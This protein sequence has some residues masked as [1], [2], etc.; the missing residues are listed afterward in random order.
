VRILIIN[1]DRSTERWAAISQQFEAWNYPGVSV[2]RF[3]AIDG[4]DDGQIAP[5]LSLVSQRRAKLVKARSLTPTQIGCYA[6]HYKAWQQC[7]E[8]REELIIVEDDASIDI[9]QLERFVAMS[10]DLPSWLNCVRLSSNHTKKAKARPVFE[11]E[12]FSVLRFSKAHMT[13]VGYYLTPEGARKLLLKSCPWFLPVDLYMGEGWLHR[14][15][16]FGVEP[17]ALEPNPSMVTTRSMR[18][19]RPKNTT[20]AVSKSLMSGKRCLRRCLFNSMCSYKEFF[21]KIW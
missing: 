3:P 13:T 16:C 19:R 9:C 18:S 1:L 20:Y 4:N 5:Y 17:T 11:N 7:L 8:S 15:P 2:E 14:V 6:S 10:A 12:Y 21:A